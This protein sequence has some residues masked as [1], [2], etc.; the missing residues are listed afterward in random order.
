M[1]RPRDANTT[2]QEEAGR[3]WGAHLVTAQ[4]AEEGEGEGEGEA[5]GGED[6]EEDQAHLVEEVTAAVAVTTKLEATRLKDSVS[7][8]VRSGGTQRRHQE[9]AGEGR[10]FRAGLTMSTR[11]VGRVKSTGTGTHHPPYHPHA[12]AHA[13]PANTYQ[14]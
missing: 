4:E 8:R 2:Y 6:G 1:T 3:T 12:N 5:E 13:H 14:A 10:A 9:A 7:F 11:A